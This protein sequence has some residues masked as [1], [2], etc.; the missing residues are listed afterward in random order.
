[1]KFGMTVML[2]EISIHRPSELLDLCFCVTTDL[3]TN[4][5]GYF[6]SEMNSSIIT[7]L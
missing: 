7:E 3:K 5:V 4:T 6:L 1:M 2:P